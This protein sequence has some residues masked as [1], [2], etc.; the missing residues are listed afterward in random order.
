MNELTPMSVWGK[1]H[2]SLL[3]YVETRVVDYDGLLDEKY[4][5]IHSLGSKE[6]DRFYCKTRLK[7]DAVIHCH[8]DQDCL[9]DLEFEG[10]VKEYDNKYSLTDYGWE[11]AA[12][13]RRHKAEIKNIRDFQP[14]ARE[15]GSKIDVPVYKHTVK[16]E[17]YHSTAKITEAKWVDILFP[18][19]TYYNADEFDKRIWQELWKQEDTRAKPNYSSWL[20]KEHTWSKDE[21]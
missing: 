21:S 7:G 9:N 12:A 18:L 2:W 11:C 16:F 5:R 8:D 20:E 4:M 17:R 19:V 10:L 3:L 6:G 15:M 13:L 1:D 14:P